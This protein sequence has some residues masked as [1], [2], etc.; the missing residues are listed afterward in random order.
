MKLEGK[1]KLEE[2]SSA[3]KQMKNNK[4]PGVDG[5]PAEFFKISW[6]KLK[7]F[8]LHALNFAI[9]TGELSVSLKTC[10]INCL[11]KDKTRNFLKNWWPIYL[12]VL[13]RCHC[14]CQ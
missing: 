10:V 11:K 9:D 1:L 7:Y 2:I 8:V 5:F 14:S 4:C 13:Y 3:L 6:D 12:S